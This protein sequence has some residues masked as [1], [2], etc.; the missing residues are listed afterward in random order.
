MPDRNRPIAQARNGFLQDFS[1]FSRH[2]LRN[3]AV[4][5]KLDFDPCPLKL[6]QVTGLFLLQRGARLVRECPHPKRPPKRLG[7]AA[8]VVPIALAAVQIVGAAPP[9]AS[10]D[11]SPSNPAV[12]DNVTFTSTTGDP[13]ADGETITLIEWDFEDNGSFDATGA[14]TTH[15]CSTD[16]TTTVRMK[17]T[18]S[19]GEV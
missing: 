18:D 19:A 9:G 15:A 4:E 5:P 6:N 16:G 3:S 7:T 2:R 13:G 1:Q 11:V 8:V 14:E 10:F 17:V 12:G